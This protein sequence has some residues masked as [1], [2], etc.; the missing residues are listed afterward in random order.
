MAFNPLIAQALQLARVISLQILLQEQRQFTIDSIMGCVV[1]V[2]RTAA[3]LFAGAKLPGA[4]GGRSSYRAD[5]LLRRIS[6][7]IRAYR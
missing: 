5:L 6:P 2:S 3:H 4:E 7:Y 1:A